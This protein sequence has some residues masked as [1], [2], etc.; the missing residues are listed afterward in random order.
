L[1]AHPGN[2]KS[3][4]NFDPGKQSVEKLSEGNKTTE[5]AENAFSKHLIL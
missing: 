1:P 4:Y 5:E 3:L 2:R